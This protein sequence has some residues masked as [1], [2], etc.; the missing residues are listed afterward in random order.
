MA[1]AARENVCYRRGTLF[2]CAHAVICLICLWVEVGRGEGCVPSPATEKSHEVIGAQGFPHWP[3][4]AIVF[5]ACIPRGSPPLP[6]RV[7]I[8]GFLLWTYTF[9]HLKIRPDS[10]RGD[11][12]LSKRFEL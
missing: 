5:L 9:F 7:L 6:R 10:Q 1:A 4:A 3:A 11:T 2:P 8:L 12:L